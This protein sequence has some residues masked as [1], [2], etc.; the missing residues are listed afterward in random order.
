M[1]LDGVVLDLFEGR[2]RDENKSNW[3]QVIVMNP[4]IPWNLVAS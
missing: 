4:Y 2:D 1:S 3:D